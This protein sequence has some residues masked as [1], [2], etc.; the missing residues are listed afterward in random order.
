MD[1]NRLH[2]DAREYQHRLQPVSGEQSQM[3]GNSL[4][5]VP[6]E[7]FGLRCEH[8]LCPAA[9]SD[10]YSGW[11]TEWIF[12]RPDGFR[13]PCCRIAGLPFHRHAWLPNLRIFSVSPPLQPWLRWPTARQIRWLTRIGARPLKATQ[14][15][16]HGNCNLTKS[17]LSRP[18]HSLPEDDM[19]TI[20]MSILTGCATL[21]R[22]RPTCQGIFSL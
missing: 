17:R 2:P 18:D 1:L 3:S 4:E 15:G 19:A 11:S 22:L 21:E 20:P 13:F 14:P 5:R 9:R 10:T 7:Q 12:G 16:S 6:G 8:K